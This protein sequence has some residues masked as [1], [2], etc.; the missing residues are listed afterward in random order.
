[1]SSPDVSLRPLA[2][3]SKIIRSIRRVLVPKFEMMTKTLCFA[4]KTPPHPTNSSHGAMNLLKAKGCHLQIKNERQFALASNQN[5][6]RRHSI[7][8]HLYPIFLNDHSL[9]KLDPRTLSPRFH[10]H[11]PLSLAK[12]CNYTEL[13]NGTYSH[14]STSLIG[15]QLSDLPNK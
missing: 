9:T 11:L 6:P 1:M 5:E 10:S 14:P 15:L 3:G 13:G 4:N 7:K 2:I 12:V 8:Q